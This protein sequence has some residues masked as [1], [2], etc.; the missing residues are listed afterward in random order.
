LTS[1]ALSIDEILKRIG[2][3]TAAVA[4]VG[5]E[6]ERPRPATMAVPLISP[7]EDDAV[8]QPGADSYR[9]DDFLAL[10]EEDFLRSA[11]RVVLGR[12]AD[13]TGLSHYL[14]ALRRRA[15]SPIG[16]LGSLRY[17]REGRARGVKIR[18]LLPAFAFDR[19]ARLPVIGWVAGPIVQLVTL[20]RTLRALERRLAAAD[21]RTQDVVS[22]ANATIGAVRTELLRSRTEIIE[23]RGLAGTADEK[24]Q[25]SIDHAEG[26]RIEL[27]AARRMIGEEARRLSA[28]LDRVE[29]GA[30][31]KPQMDAVADEEGLDALYVAFE[32]KFRGSTSEILERTKRYLPLF[33]VSEPVTRGGVVLDIGCGRGE[34]LSVLEENR[35]KARGIDLN[36]AM[37]AEAAAR[38]HDVTEGD[39]LGYLR[40]QPDNSLAAVTGFHIIEHLPFRMLVA[41]LDELARVL[42][43]GGIILFETPNPENLVVGACTF[44]YDPT[45]LK[46]LPPDLMR[47]LAEARGFEAARIIRTADDC[48]LDRPESGFT[49]TEVNDWFRQPPDYA[50][51]ARKPV[52]AESV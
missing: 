13:S 50:V 15:T 17:S 9:L 5:A 41:V 2:A 1:Q 8:P 46:A 45:H 49:P 12:E 10:S 16:V 39:A 7:W 31:E 18:R 34:W 40:A 43:P 29:T 30:P 48:D 32:N 42:E 36:G 37:V 33:R 4:P 44:N 22:S 11:Y 38:G 52:A 3:D 21:S 25:S 28:V 26:A 14:P 19:L 6:R 35:I 47:F 23:A 24:A 51:F 27:A 20:P